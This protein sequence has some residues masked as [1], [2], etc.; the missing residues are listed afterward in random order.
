MERERRR[1]PRHG[2]FRTPAYEWDNPFSN[3][4]AADAKMWLTLIGW[5]VRFSYRLPVSA[6][7]VAPAPVMLKALLPDWAPEFLL[8]YQKTVIV[9][10]GDFFGGIPAVLDQAALGQA[11]LKQS[12]WKVRVVNEFELESKSPGKILAEMGVRG[13]PGSAG[14]VLPNPYGIPDTME[15]FRRMRATAKK[16]I[17]TNTR[18]SY[19]PLGAGRVRPGERRR[20]VRAGRGF[21]PGRTYRRRRNPGA[22]RRD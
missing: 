7:T 21:T 15:R 18:V 1:Y 16:Y 12:G 4:S 19:G 10:L 20:G 5:G 13:T 9:I 3:I 17:S 14:Q 22:T 6:W 8:P 2:G 11:I